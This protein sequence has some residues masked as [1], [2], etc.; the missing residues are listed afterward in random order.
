MKKVNYIG[1][2]RAVRIMTATVKKNL[3]IFGASS[4][5]VLMELESL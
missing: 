1:L 5:G 3:L 2:E 4:V